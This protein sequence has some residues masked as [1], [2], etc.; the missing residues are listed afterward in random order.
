MGFRMRQSIRIAPGIRLN[1]SAKSLG[2]SAGVR[3]AR[4]SLNSRTG[5]RTT[6]S[7]PG[8][9]LSYTTTHAVHPPASGGRG[10]APRA[11]PASP[12]VPQAPHPGLFAPHWHKE[13]FAALQQGRT[14][15][16]EPIA[17]RHPEARATCM[18]LE[19]LSPA[20]SGEGGQRAEQML[21]ELWSTGYDPE[22]DEFLRTYAPGSTTSIRLTPILV[23][24]LPL[25]RDAIGLA[26]AELIQETG[27]LDGAIQVVEGVTPSTYAA[28]SLA[29]LYSEAGRWSDVVALTDGVPNGDDFCTY[30][31]IQ[32]G[33]A[34]R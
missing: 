13:L 30:L 1:V 5:V 18:V 17:A 33:V 21:G 25:S 8:T 31:L 29:D 26:L 9:G 27:N 24:T 34:F 32:R 15:G 7:L 23:A 20:T 14:T 3:G 12:P 16:L 28:V 10:P 2:I 4:V 11:L 19:A 6:A 22:S